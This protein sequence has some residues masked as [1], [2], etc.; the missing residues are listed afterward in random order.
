MC[1]VN[2]TVYVFSSRTQSHMG[3]RLIYHLTTAECPVAPRAENGER[4]HTF[5][6]VFAAMEAVQSLCSWIRRLCEHHTVPAEV[7]DGHEPPRSTSHGRE[8]DLT[9]AGRL[10]A[11]VCVCNGLR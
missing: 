9:T 10:R 7:C 11:D 4:M 2:V 1:S 5:V 3:V 8:I 6:T